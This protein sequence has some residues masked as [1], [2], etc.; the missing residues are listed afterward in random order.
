V[1]K[2]NEWNS[3]DLGYMG[4]PLNIGILLSLHVASTK[5]E[6]DYL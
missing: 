4:G 2:Q 6:M 3:R 5:N 1:Q